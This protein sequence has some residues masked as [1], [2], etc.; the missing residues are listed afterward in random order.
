MLRASPSWLVNQRTSSRSATKTSSP[1][2]TGRNS[3]K[4]E[5]S[6]RIATRAW[7][8]AAGSWAAITSGSLS[9]NWRMQE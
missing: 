4:A 6:R 8:S 9:R 5:R 2:I 7:C 3:E 1:A